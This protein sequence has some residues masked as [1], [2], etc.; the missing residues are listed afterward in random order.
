MGGARGAG[1]RLIG[2]ELLRFLAAVAVLIW[3][4]QHFM[5]IGHQHTAWDWSRL[6]FR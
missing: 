4:Y 3:H 2:L 1:N 6:P 5:F